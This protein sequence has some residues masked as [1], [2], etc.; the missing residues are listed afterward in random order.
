MSK[1]QAETKHP[2]GRPRKQ[3]DQ[4]Q[5]EF[6]CGIQCTEEEIAAFFDCSKDTISRWCVQTYEQ[7]FADVFAEK[8]LKGKASLRRAQ[9]ALA[10]KNAAMAIFLGKNYLG[11]KNE[12]GDAASMK[13]ALEQIVEAIRSVE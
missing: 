5:F 3:I 11:Q 4:K 1:K 2:G 12:D 13:G 6:L 9:F 7:C 8:R 10:Q